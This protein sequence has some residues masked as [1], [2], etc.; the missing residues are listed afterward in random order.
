MR[1]EAGDRSDYY[2]KIYTGISHFMSLQ[3]ANA[4]QQAEIEV[5]EVYMNYPHQ[6]G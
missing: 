5:S 2:E 1:I 6:I 3:G 4:I